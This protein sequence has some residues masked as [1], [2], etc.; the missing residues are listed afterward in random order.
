MERPDFAAHDEWFD[1]FVASD[2]LIGRLYRAD[3]A[4]ILDLV[5]SL[6][7]YERAGL[8]AFCYRRSHLHPVGLIIASTCEQSTLMQVLGT[9]VGTVLFAQSRARKPVVSRVPGGHRAKIT[10]AKIGIA[11]PPPDDGLDEPVEIE[12]QAGELVVA[13]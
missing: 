4:V 7:P 6:Q 2:A 10:L 13:L 9:A 1:E 3:E 11:T 12:E 8:A 5:S